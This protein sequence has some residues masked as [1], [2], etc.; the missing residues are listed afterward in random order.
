MY[1]DVVFAQGEDATEPLEVLVNKGEKAAID[2]L[3]QWHD[4]GKHMLR[5]QPSRGSADSVFEKDGY[6]L[7]W[8][9]GLGYIGLEHKLYEDQ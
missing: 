2:Y 9:H 4:P 6:I 1:E 5:E 3:T 8:N 7:T